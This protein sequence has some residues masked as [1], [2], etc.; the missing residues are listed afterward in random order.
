MDLAGDDH[1][2]AQ[3]FSQ[4]A[5]ICGVGLIWDRAG[6]DVYDAHA[7]CQGAGMFGLGLLLDS[8]GSRITACI[9]FEVGE[10]IE[11]K[12]DNFVEEVMAQ[13][14]GAG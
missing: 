4:A 11:K 6:S 3:H 5:G 13:V 8:A 9:R 10:G 14:K 2:R 7:F 12:E 1:Y